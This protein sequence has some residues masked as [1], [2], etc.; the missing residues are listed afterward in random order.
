[1]EPGVRTKHGTFN[2]LLMTFLGHIFLIT[3]VAAFSQEL[4][5][6][7]FTQDNQICRYMMSGDCITDQD[8]HFPKFWFLLQVSSLTRWWQWLRARGRSSILGVE[9]LGRLFSVVCC[10]ADCSYYYS[11]SRKLLLWFMSTFI[12]LWTLLLN[13]V[14]AEPSHPDLFLSVLSENLFDLVLSEIT[15]WGN[16]FSAMWTVAEIFDGALVLSLKFL[17]RVVIMLL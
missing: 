10:A 2:I 12:V 6:R 13:T 16:I 7:I 4:T 9:S 14:D 15:F 3:W 8:S 5:I 1:M 17:V 11:V